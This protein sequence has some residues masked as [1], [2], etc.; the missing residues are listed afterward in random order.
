MIKYFIKRKLSK[1]KTTLVYYSKH[2]NKFPQLTENY[3][4]KINLQET[5]KK[6]FR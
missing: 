1:T 4:F 3:E 2:K 6:N 5:G